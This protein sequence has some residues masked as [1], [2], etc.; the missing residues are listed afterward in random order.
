MNQQTTPNLTLFDLLARHWKRPSPVREIRFNVDDTLLAARGEDGTVVFARM[1]DNEPPEARI[2]TEGGQTGLKPREGR[3]AP[4]IITRVKDGSAIA[5]DAGGGFLCGTGEGRLVRLS[6]AGE[7]SEAMKVADH[8]VAAL[9]RN[10]E[11]ERIVFVAGD[12]LTLLSGDGE[13]VELDL[14]GT[15][16]DRI[17]LSPDGTR[18]ALA[19]GERLE[20]RVV[21]SA[22]RSVFRLPV[23]AAVL[24]LA[25]SGDGRWLAAGLERHGLCLVDAIAG[26]PVQIEDFPGPVADLC[27]GGEG[28]FIAAG[29]YRIA[30]WSMQPPPIA[31]SADGSLLTGRA[32]LALVTAV[33]AQPAGRLVAAGY[34]N[35]QVVVAPLGSREDLIVRP[36]GA[37]VT[38]LAWTADGRHLALGDEGGTLA[39][40]TF[41]AQ[42]FK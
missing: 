39:V 24:T 36:A 20:I 11:T 30:A 28:A 21:G 18:L 29:A 17:A 41:P 37:P 34:A 40:V 2:V 4:L 23:P 42:L 9:E 1:A 26:R 19:G 16:T 15:A 14:A 6:R 7:T 32:G 10:A 31:S 25:W 27:F 8:A 3:P 22:M 13:R 12:R 38:A 5:A 35:G 33:S